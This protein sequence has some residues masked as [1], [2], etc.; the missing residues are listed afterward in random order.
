MTTN[1]WTVLRR[2]LWAAVFSLLAPLAVLAQADKVDYDA[3]KALA[4]KVEKQI[5]SPDRD[6]AALDAL[7][8]QVSDFRTTFQ[9]A[10]DANS[11]RIDTLTAQISAL[12]E[13]PAEGETEPQ[14]IAK[15]RADLNKQLQEAEV[16]RLQAEEA[17]R[18][19]DGLITEIDRVVRRQQAEQLFS[20]GP[21]PLN[22]ALWTEA[23][24]TAI[25]YGLALVQEVR[26]TFADGARLSSIREDVLPAILFIIFG[27]LLL[28]RAPDWIEALVNQVWHRIKRGP[29]V[30][31]LL[32]SVGKVILPVLGVVMMVS[33]LQVLQLTGD[34]GKA[35]LSDMRIYVG[36]AMFAGWLSGLLFPSGDFR[37]IAAIP[38]HKRAKARRGGVILGLCVAMY[39]LL[40]D[41]ATR[42]DFSTG[43]TAVLM[44]PMIILT[45]FALL[46]LVNTLRRSLIR[47]A[48]AAGNAAPNLAMI[49]LRLMA[50]GALL[51]PVIAAIGYR[52]AA[53]GLLYPM[54][55]SLALYGV[56][57][58]LQQFIRDLYAMFSSN[59][60]KADDALLPVL[61]GYLLALG[62]LPA[63]ALIWGARIS[64]LTELWARFRAGYTIGD[65]NISP[66]D[67]ISF[68]VVFVIGYGITRLLQRALQTS[69]LP[70]TRLD[71]GGRNAMVS[72][73][74]YVGIFIAA[75]AAVGAAGIDLSNLA[76]VAGALSV[77][78]GFGLQNI[79]SNFVSGI[80]LLIERPISEGDWIEVGGE[81]GYVRA[82]SVRSTRIETFDRTDVI[83]PNSDLVSGKV[84]NWTR[85]NTIG[86]VIVSVG[87]AYGTDSR[88]VEK[89]LME[90]AKEHP[91]V[92]LQPPPFIYFKG[93]GDSSLD[94]EVR[95]IIRDVNWVLNVSSDFN[96]SIVKRFAEEGIEIPFP[97]RDVWVHGSAIHPTPVPTAEPVRQ[98][99]AGL[100]DVSADGADE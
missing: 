1:P 43:V 88:R 36:L 42:E 26:D 89:I 98:A 47:N 81:M 73:M 31:S 74:G 16:P 48:E 24:G 53:E 18:Q 87:V 85:G 93:F 27:V 68:A 63:L 91:M 14:T 96:H 92:L 17:Y 38:Q 78:I 37:A 90:I 45:A 10:Q 32:I 84:T 72:G 12:G 4:S 6:A 100:P 95:A 83:V 44:F 82:I 25:T 66:T 65:T 20:L 54:V 50:F 71:L 7:R 94:F 15:R 77:G 55:G 79:V 80:I 99:A 39:L 21:T 2:L 59:P 52:N 28:T 64:D 49:V 97:Q 61:L 11:E 33:G 3:W 69:I 29:G 5:D 57:A 46:H 51:S 8:A 22:P 76:I 41:V 56:Y 34:R 35:L 62:L 19:A 75:M 58:V 40:N 13:K 23:G 86:R 67:F 70:K 30:W 60:D 9:S